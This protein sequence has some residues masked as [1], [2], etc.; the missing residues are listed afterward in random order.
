MSHRFRAIAWAL[1]ATVAM[2]AIALIGLG[3]DLLGNVLA[4]MA[5]IALLVAPGILLGITRRPRRSMRLLDLVLA[6]TALSLGLVVIGGLLLNLLPGGLGRTTWL[7]FV[8]VLLVATAFLAR[9]D[10]AALRLPRFA[11]PSGRQWIAM[12]ATVGLVVAALAVARAGVR[13]PSE[14]YS[15]LWV[16]PATAGAVTI[17]LDNHETAA[18][19]YRVD[20]TTGGTVTATFGSITLGTGERWT[21]TIA[22]PKAGEP[23]LDVRL[24][25]ESEPDLVYRRVTVSP[26]L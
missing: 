13:Q 16:V 24:Y 23:R 22:A 1:G 25:L 14:P 17:G 5:G 20:V 3:R 8:V 15:A 19:T 26:G 11:V 7:G 4:A 10:G 6:S 9:S 21:T 18:T 2:L 12:V